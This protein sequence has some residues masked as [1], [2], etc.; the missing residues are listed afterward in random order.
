VV[1]RL[2]SEL[3]ASS[4]PGIPDETVT[5]SVGVAMFGE[6]GTTSEELLAAADAAMYSDKRSRKELVPS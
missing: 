2:R 6:D 5:V 3:A 4:L 1:N